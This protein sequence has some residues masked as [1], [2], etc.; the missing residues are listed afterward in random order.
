VKAEFTRPD[1][2][3]HVVGRAIWKPGIPVIESDDDEVRAALGRMFRPVP[4]VIDDASLR[5]FG[6]SGP[7]VLQ[8]GSL[9]W[10]RAAAE[11]RAA[12]E[13]LAVRFVGTTETA[14]GWDPAGAYR[15]FAASDAR[16]QAG[17]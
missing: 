14:M 7:V 8:P 15:T 5:S 3:D 9:R 4:V 12:A 16:R 1:A 11:T 13:D 17:P 6:T 2:S 10:F